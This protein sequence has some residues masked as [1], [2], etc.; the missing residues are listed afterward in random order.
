MNPIDD[1]SKADFSD[2]VSGIEAM[3]GRRGVPDDVRSAAREILER[4]NRSNGFP[5]FPLEGVV[6]KS[7]ALRAP[8]GFTA[9]IKR[10]GIADPVVVDHTT[11]VNVME[12]DLYEIKPDPAYKPAAEVPPIE[13]M[14]NDEMTSRALDLFK[15]ALGAEGESGSL[16]LT[17]AEAKLGYDLCEASDGTPCKCR[18]TGGTHMCQPIVN[19]VRRI[20]ST[21]GEAG[22]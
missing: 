8:P 14:G 2:I 12:G 15:T 18:E 13:T 3:V 20:N 6:V 7:V 5:L 10:L 9:T 17:A 4:N 22:E 19:M 21:K 11:W 1:R 16:N